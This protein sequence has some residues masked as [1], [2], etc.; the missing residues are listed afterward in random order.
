MTL[1]TCDDYLNKVN[2]IITAS[3]DV[4]TTQ[5]NLSTLID[6]LATIDSQ[7]DT[8]IGT[9][10]IPNTTEHFNKFILVQNM[11]MTKIN[12]QNSFYNLIKIR[13]EEL[14]T[15]EEQQIG[16]TQ[17]RLNYEEE[18]KSIKLY[19]DTV[20]NSCSC[21]SGRTNIIKYEAYH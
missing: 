4:E 3:D 13:N 6:A 5:T 20:K 2:E 9:M 17:D 15:R 14:K 8:D 16:T 21:M 12:L 1:Q 7:V 11:R 18:T 10:S 19:I